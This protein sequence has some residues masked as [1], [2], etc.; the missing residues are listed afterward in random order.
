VA[1]H[2]KDSGEVKIGSVLKRGGYGHADRPPCSAEEIQLF[3]ERFQADPRNF[4]AQPT[5]E[6]FTGALR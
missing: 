1:A 2:L 4:I 3:A 5:L 6:L